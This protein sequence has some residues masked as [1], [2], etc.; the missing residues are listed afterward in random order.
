MKEDLVLEEKK[1]KILTMYLP[2]FHQTK[3]NDEWWGEGFTEW[4]AVKA[5]EPLFEGH[6]QPRVPMNNYYYDLLSKD[7]FEFQVKLMKE[8]GIDGQC[9][10]HYFF[11]DGKMVLDK[12]V[13]NLLKW[14]DI[15]MPFC[16][17]WANGTWSR[18]WS[19]LS[20][21]SWSEKFEKASNKG[22][23]NGILLEQKYGREKLWK[24]HFEYFLP[25]FEDKRYIRVNGRPLLVIH[26]PNSI[27]CLRAM[28]EYW[29]ELAKKT[30][31]QNIY[32]VVMG[33]D[34]KSPE[35]D[36]G[37]YPAPHMF[38]NP[39]CMKK[40][41]GVSRAVFDDIWKGILESKAEGSKRM[42]FEGVGDVDDTPRR[43]NRGGVAVEGYTL[44]KFY[45]YMKKLFIKSVEAGNELV[46]F[47][48]WNEWGEGMYLEPD[49]LCGTQR[50]QMLYKA[51]QEAMEINAAN[52][53]ER[54]CKKTVTYENLFQR[55]CRDLL[56]WCYSY[57]RIRKAVVQKKSFSRLLIEND[58]RTVVFYKRGII[59]YYIARQ[60]RKHEIRC[61][62]MTCISAVNKKRISDSDA[63]I[64]IDTRNYDKYYSKVRNMSNIGII[65]AREL[66]DEG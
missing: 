9:F 38:W 56:E 64:I 43:G 47:N 26:Q 18:T 21:N 12:P 25:Y 42:Y 23:D 59:S 51:K 5:A 54:D 44:E 1:V 40:T 29:R 16:F 60:L 7:T 65:S 31:I 8:F 27:A 52:D 45:L 33:T 28:I 11:K 62:F 35:V 4:V 10:Y 15:D 37:L 13:E 20:G 17:C 41:N 34:V 32:V 50:L 49:E 53:T 30:S 36:A 63:V 66:V 24:E 48:A 3:E 46:F 39:Q 61:V 58:I 19:K 57:G 2:Q 55:I 14:K 6:N 22:A